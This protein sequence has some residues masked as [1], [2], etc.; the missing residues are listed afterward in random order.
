MLTTIVSLGQTIVVC[1]F[2][3]QS[4]RGSRYLMSNAPGPGIYA[5]P[6]LL[7]TQKDFNKSG[8]TGNFHKPIAVRIED[9]P[10]HVKPAPNAYNVR[11]CSLFSYKC[12]TVKPV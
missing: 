11:L 3:F 2:H 4:K 10:K 5:L 12:C 7:T 9:D 1:S 6:A 8:T